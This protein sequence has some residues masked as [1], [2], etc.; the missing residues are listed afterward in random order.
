[1]PRFNGFFDLISDAVRYF[2]ENGFTSQTDL[3]DWVARI[4]AA[5]QDELVPEREVEEQLRRA[6][7]GIYTRMIERGQIMR[8]NPGLERFAL[9]RVKPR[10][11]AELD[12]RIL[13]SANLIK[14]NRREAVETTLRRLAGWATSIPPDG[15]GAID[16]RQTAREIRRDV[17]FLAFR[18][19]RVAIDQGAKFASALSQIVATDGGALAMQW[20]RHFTQNPREN[21]KQRDRKW[22]L[23]RNSWAHKAGLVKP[24]SGL[25]YVDEHE[26]PGELVFCF[27]G[28]TLV[29]GADRVEVAYRR[30]FSGKLTEIVVESGKTLRA[31]PNHPILTPRGWVPIGLL[32]EGDHVV[33][34]SGDVAFPIEEYGDQAVP[35]ISEVFASC[36]EGG[37]LKQANGRGIQFHGDGI[38]DRDVDVVFVARPLSFG[39]QASIDDGFEQLYLAMSDRSRFSL[40]N[41][42]C[43]LGTVFG[44]P[45]SVVSCLG[46]ASALIRRHIGHA[47]EHLFGTYVPHSL[48]SIGGQCFSS[49][50]SHSR[51]ASGSSFA[52]RPEGYARLA[53]SSRN[54]SASG[55]S[56]DVAG[57]ESLLVQF[58]DLIDVGAKIGISTEM[59]LPGSDL[60][61]L[62]SGIRE[63]SMHL[64]AAKFILRVL[65]LL[66]SVSLAVGCY[67]PSGSA[68]YAAVVRTRDV[69]F[70]GHVYNLQTA[71]GWYAPGAIIAHNCRCTGLYVYSLRDLP[72]EMLTAKGKAELERVRKAA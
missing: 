66:R 58:D 18:D 19:R 8:D 69:D 10:L 4:R 21:H 13:A 52:S 12:R 67:P 35:A 45:N 49:F 32:N 22:Y 28:D 44:S 36:L 30:W 65:S 55:Q 72:D 43:F 37:F 64:P 47:L 62:S 53:Q 25:G 23:M 15:T 11:R 54:N 14:L 50:I 5:A 24:I 61:R 57:A 63:D 3:D 40:S 68:N 71:A 9:E 70:V 42:G 20:H 2:A 48:V 31:T 6:L 34:V 29:H 17:S 51:L 41:L 46:E 39:R 56:L 33:E 1:M 27:P 38:S 59:A 7:G 16:K 26:Q 60:D